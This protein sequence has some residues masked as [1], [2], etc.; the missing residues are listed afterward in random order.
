MAEQVRQQPRRMSVATFD[1]V[2]RL[3]TFLR[4]IASGGAAVQLSFVF[5]LFRRIRLVM[6]HRSLQQDYPT[7]QFYADWLHHHELDRAA[8]VWTLADKLDQVLVGE[9]ERPVDET[10]QSLTAAVGL[11]RLRKEMI[12][13]FRAIG[14]SNFLFTSRS[15]WYALVGPILSDLSERP[16]KFRYPVPT[17][18][19]EVCDRMVSRRQALGKGSLPLLGELRIVDRCNDPGE[20]GRP[21]GFYLEISFGPPPNNAVVDAQLLVHEPRSVFVAD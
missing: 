20:P 21:A 6:Q 7:A 14:V 3:A 16:I 1:P 13:M 15:N 17:R 11:A 5:D 9:G 8:G 4:P 18:L 10:L 12:E 19:Q 2:E